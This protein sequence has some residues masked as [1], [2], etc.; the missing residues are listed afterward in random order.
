MSFN[1]KRTL[2]LVVHFFDFRNDVRV[3]L[4]G[5]VDLGHRVVV[6]HQAEDEEAIKRHA[7]PGIEFREMR[8]Q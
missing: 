8:E 2:G 4:A 6:F 3:L 1:T 7:P 5:L